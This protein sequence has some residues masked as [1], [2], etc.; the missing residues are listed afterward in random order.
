M[1]GKKM[2]NTGKDSPHYHKE[3]RKGKQG[4][5]GV[6]LADTTKLHEKHSFAVFSTLRLKKPS[7]QMPEN[8][9]AITYT[10]MLRSFPTLT[11]LG[12]Y[13]CR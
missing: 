10:V 12:L 7:Q 2:S 3:V 4:W 11:I 8:H 13:V 5:Q 6:G 1:P 9:Y